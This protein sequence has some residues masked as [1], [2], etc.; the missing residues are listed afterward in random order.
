MSNVVFFDGVCNLCNWSVDFIIKRDTEGV[1][2]FASLQSDVAKGLLDEHR[3]IVDNGMRTIVLLK[4]DRLYYRSDA[5]LE[6][7]RDLS[8]PWPLLSMFKVIP[9]FIRD[10]VYRIIS[11]NRYRWFGQRNTCRVPTVE[12]QQRFLESSNQAV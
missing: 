1:F 4:N 8:N 7:C 3:S 5:V 10:A 6:I 11:K 9:R 12:E 2:K